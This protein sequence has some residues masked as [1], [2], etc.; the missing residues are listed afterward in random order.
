MDDKNEIE[1][2][3]GVI[4]HQ[5]K[6]LKNEIRALKKEYA[7]WGFITAAFAGIIIG[8]AAVM[9]VIFALVN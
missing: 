6:I 1:R 2:L 5:D 4:A 9:F 7:E 8:Y 3:N